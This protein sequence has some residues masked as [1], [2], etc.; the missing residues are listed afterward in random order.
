MNIEMV[1]SDNI[2]TLKAKVDEIFS[3]YEKKIIDLFEK[4]NP[5][6]LKDSSS[7]LE[8]PSCDIRLPLGVFVKTEKHLK[9]ETKG[10]ID[11]KVKFLTTENIIERTLIRISYQEGYQGWITDP[12]VFNKFLTNIK[13]KKTVELLF[14]EIFLEIGK[15]IKEVLATN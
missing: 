1:T 11:C 12:F 9:F 14:E 13:H 6:A 8:T 5:Y 3:S 7:N 10:Y 15:T 2:Q 4:T